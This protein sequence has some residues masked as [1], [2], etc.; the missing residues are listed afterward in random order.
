MGETQ[1]V[2][3]E[4]LVQKNKSRIL[5]TLKDLG[6]VFARWEQRFPTKILTPEQQDAVQQMFPEHRVTSFDRVPRYNIAQMTAPTN[7]PDTLKK[8]DPEKKEFFDRHLVKGHFTAPT[9]WRYSVPWK[10]ADVDDNLVAILEHARSGNDAL[11]QT[12][13]RVSRVLANSDYAKKKRIRNFDEYVATHWDKVCTTLGLDREYEIVAT[14]KQH[15][16]DDVRSSYADATVECNLATRTLD[17]ILSDPSPIRPQRCL[18]AD[19]ILNSK[20]YVLDIEKPL[21]STDAEELSWFQGVL[22][23]QG[24]AVKKEIKT[25]RDT[26]L[27]TYNDWAVTQFA[28]P[29]DIVA[30]ATADITNKVNNKTVDVLIA[31]NAPYDLE[32]TREAGDFDVGERQSEPKVQ[33]PIPFFRKDVVHGRLVLDPFAAARIRY[34]HLPNRKFGLVLAE[35]LGIEDAKLVNYDQLQQLEKTAIDG[36]PDHLSPDTIRIVAKEHQIKETDVRTHPQLK[37]LCAQVELRYGAA[38]VDNLVAMFQSPWF[39][40][41][42]EDASWMSDQFGIDI[43]RLLHSPKT[44]NDAQERVYW[45]FVGTYRDVVYL[46]T[47]QMIQLQHKGREATLDTIIAKLIEKSDSGLHENVAKV[48]LPLGDWLAQHVAGENPEN[49]QRRFTD[50]HK[51]RDY[52]TAHRNDNLRYFTLM[53][54]LTSLADYIII[55]YGLYQRAK[56]DQDKLFKAYNLTPDDFERVYDRIK[57]DFTPLTA[58]LME[59]NIPTAAFMGTYQRFA[60]QLQKESEHGLRHLHRGTLTDAGI[61]RHA[62]SILDFCDRYNVTATTFA[63]LCKIKATQ[64]SPFA[65]PLTQAQ[66]DTNPDP[67][68]TQFMMNHK[69]DTPAV[70]ELLK[71]YALVQKRKNRLAG[72]YNAPVA[73]IDQ[74]LGSKIAAIQGFCETHGLDIIHAQ[75]GYLYVTGKNIEAL[76]QPDSPLILVDTLPRAYVTVNPALPG[77][78]DRDDLETKIFYKKHGYY[79]GIKVTDRPS[80]NLTLFEMEC[81]TPIIQYILDNDEDAAIAHAKEKL[82]ILRDMVEEKCAEIK[83]LTET[84]PREHID[85]G[86]YEHLLTLPKEQFLW[87]AKRTNRYRGWEHGEKI[88]FVTD[89]RF[90]SGELKTENGRTYFETPSRKGSDELRKVY[91]MPIAQFHPDVAKFYDHVKNRVADLLRPL[92]GI[93]ASFALT[94][95]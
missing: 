54:Y 6:T 14:L 10:V 58:K 37:H 72:Q 76:A 31:Y 55:D 1:Y 75:S 4:V 66:L 2:L 57:R 49:T 50:V 73:L 41:M 62:D 21:F 71:A 84:L 23:D 90:A 47:K 30:S 40:T 86:H 51:L 17:I 83:G 64:K 3:S 24:K 63:E 56:N 43:S 53:S 95:K 19:E 32:N 93:D 7:L 87:F 67:C 78:R 92:I 38:D 85:E 61:I 35:S 46:K 33:V 69:L 22:L 48:A 60:Q 13:T 36:N 27:K 20:V 11:C 39:R 28:T 94:K 18:T 80:Y 26:G 70:Q 5:L 12:V 74:T 79:E 88:Q 45:E 8:T 15:L 91:V 52:A 25:L 9:R 42:L 68:N 89:K 65:K 44:I 29:H 81:Y 77:K 82:S 59:L 34:R 16:A